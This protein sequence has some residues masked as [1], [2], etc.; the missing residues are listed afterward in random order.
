MNLTQQKPLLFAENKEE[1]INSYIFFDTETTGTEEDDRIIQIAAIVTNNIPEENNYTLNELVSSPVPIKIEAMET[2]HITP[3]MIE[4]KSTFNENEIIK[5]FFK[6]INNQS[7]FLIAHNI[8]FDIEQLKKE[9]FEN[10][11]H[12]I[13]TLRIAKHLYQKEVNSLR[14]QHLRY[15]FELYKLETNELE[16]NPYLENIILSAHDAL[17]DVV[18]LK[19]LFKKLFKDIQERFELTNK[20]KVIEK[21][22][23]LTNTPVLIYKFNFGKHKDKTFEEVAKTDRNYLEWLS[24]NMEQKDLD[25]TYTIKHYLS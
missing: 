15:A 18:V 10:E 14:L 7:N 20:Q 5:T 23:E 16:N 13:D 8:N 2:H 17:G 6:K 4:T 21:M 11:T 3:N 22:I 24:K 25:L 1:V 12:L 9:G 19:L